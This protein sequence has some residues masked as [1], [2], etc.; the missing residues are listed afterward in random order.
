MLTYYVLLVLAWLTPFAE[1]H[2]SY[3]III[4]APVVKVR[5]TVRVRG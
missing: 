3:F 1:A 4:S 2:A 5:V